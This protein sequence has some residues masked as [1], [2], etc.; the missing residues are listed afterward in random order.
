MLITSIDE[1]ESLTLY[2]SWWRFPEIVGI[3]KGTPEYRK[4]QEI[5]EDSTGEKITK[6]TT[7]GGRRADAEQCQ[8][9]P[10]K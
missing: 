9:I 6:I 7:L 3:Q 5:W 10:K 1:N 2:Q 4:Y 8:E